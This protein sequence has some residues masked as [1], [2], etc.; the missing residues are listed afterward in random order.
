M[1]FI[2]VVRVRHTVRPLALVVFNDRREHL[3]TLMSLSGDSARW[4][5]TDIRM[6]R[7]EIEKTI[8][9]SSSS[10]FLYIQRAWIDKC[11]GTYKS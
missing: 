1:G 11:H 7:K 3:C 4:R 2:R 8:F 5:L 6:G 10:A 9:S